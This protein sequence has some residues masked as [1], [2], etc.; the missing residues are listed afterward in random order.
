M[1]CN[2]V[3]HYELAYSCNLNG[4]FE[5]RRS[6]HWLLQA[7]ANLGCCTCGVRCQRRA[8]GCQSAAA[9]AQRP[10]QGMFQTEF[11]KRAGQAEGAREAGLTA[12][13]AG[14]GVGALAAGG[15]APG[16]GA[17]RCGRCV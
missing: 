15:R 4:K 8:I 14:G 7:G 12:D 11:F 16:A 5:L 9:P 10:F 13:S 3:L 1:C 17:G 6:D 2:H